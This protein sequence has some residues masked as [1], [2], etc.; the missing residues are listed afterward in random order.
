MIR[1]ARP[2]V[3][4][5]RVPVRERAALGVLARE[6]DRDPVLE[7]RR[8]R[9]RLGVTPV[10]PALSKRVAPALE[11]PGELRVDVEALGDSKQ[12]FVELEEAIRRYR[13]DDGGA[14]VRSR[15]VARPAESGAAKRV[16]GA[17]HATSRSVA[18]RR[19]R[20]MPSRLVRADDAV[21]DQARAYVSRTGTC[22]S[23]RSDC[24]GCVYAASSCS[25]WPK[26]R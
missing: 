11:L 6:P 23:M 26:R 19:P 17:R 9:E 25:L 18:E 1:L 24:S 7:Q 22:C 21:G 5:H 10:D 2:R 12:L 20:D 8:E 3:V 13:R 16:P 4:Q 14:R 15:S